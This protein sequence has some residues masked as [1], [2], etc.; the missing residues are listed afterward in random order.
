MWRTV[1]PALF[2]FFVERDGGPGRRDIFPPAGVRLWHR[3]SPSIEMLIL[4][5]SLDAK[6]LQKHTEAGGDEILDKL[7]VPG[8]VLSAIRWIRAGE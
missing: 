6:N 2:G 3:T 5:A 4:S 1:I 8:E 7:G